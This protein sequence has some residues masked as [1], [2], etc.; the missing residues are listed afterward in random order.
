MHHIVTGNTSRYHQP[1]TF[2]RF[3]SQCCTKSTPTVLTAVCF[4][5]YHALSHLNLCVPIKTCQVHFKSNTQTQRSLSPIC[6]EQRLLLQIPTITTDFSLL[7]NVRTGSG[8]NCTGSGAN[9]TGSGAHRTG[10]GTQTSSYETGTLAYFPIIMQPRR[11]VDNSPPTKAEVKN[12]WSY[13]STP[14]ICFNGM[15]TDNFTF[16]LFKVSVS[17]KN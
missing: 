9:C 6:S 10:S 5:A 8:A 14:R 16:T 12:Q 1:P 7:R 2:C 11:G 4:A 13:T 15:G 17:S 3:S